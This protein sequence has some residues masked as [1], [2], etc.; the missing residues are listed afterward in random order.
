MIIKSSIYSLLISTTIFMLLFLMISSLGEIEVNNEKIG[1][2][3]LEKKTFF[4]WENFSDCTKS[5]NWGKNNN[6]GD[7]YDKAFNTKNN[8]STISDDTTTLRFF[9]IISSQLGRN[10]L[11]D[12]IYILL[13]SCLFI[14]VWIFSLAYLGEEIP[15]K[16]FYL[17]DWSINSAPLLGVLGTISAFSALVSSSQYGDMQELFKQNFFTAAITTII[18]G[19]IYVFNLLLSFWIIPYL[20]RDRSSTHE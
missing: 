7:C 2:S 11:F 16:Y 5:E 10:I 20:S 15:K 12:A 9:E 4:S 19:F 18:G 1:T 13:F 8:I 17:S 6:D 3:Q 14:Q